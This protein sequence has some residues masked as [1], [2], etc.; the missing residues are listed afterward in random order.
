MA[1]HTQIIR[2]G[3]K[4]RVYGGAVTNSGGSIASQMR[5]DISE[6]VEALDSIM[7]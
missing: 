6:I 4:Y 7:E 3:E 1:I 5:S 2:F